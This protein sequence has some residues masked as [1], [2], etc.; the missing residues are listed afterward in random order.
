[1][2]DREEDF[3]QLL[4]LTPELDDDGFTENLMLRL[5]ARR[6]FERVRI[7]LMLAFSFAGCG[8]AASVSGARHFLV[9]LVSGFASIPVVANLS[10][11]TVCVVAALLIWGAVAAATSEA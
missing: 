3:E 10:L 1:M 9:E 11:L 7:A 4:S 8:I 6:N 2:R 5:P